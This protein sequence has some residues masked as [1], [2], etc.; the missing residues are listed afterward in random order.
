MSDTHNTILPL[1]NENNNSS[2][3]LISSY[4]QIEPE[5]TLTPNSA[6]FESTN[7]QYHHI[8]MDTRGEQLQ[9]QHPFGLVAIK[10]IPP[11]DDRPLTHNH[12]IFTIDTSY[13]MNETC[14]GIGRLCKLDFIKTSITNTLSLFNS[15]ANKHSISITV[16]LFNDCIQILIDNVVVNNDTIEHAIQLIQTVEAKNGT[17]IEKAM[18]SAKTIIQKHTDKFSTHTITHIFLTDGIPTLGEHS[19]DKL[20]N[21]IPPNINNVFI[22]YGG[23]HDCKLL[24]ELGQEDKCSYHFVDNSKNAGLVLG[25]IVDGILYCAIK[26]ARFVINNGEIY[27]YSTNTWVKELK[28]NSISYETEHLLHIQSQSKNATVTLYG[29]I[30]ESNNIYCAEEE[31]CKVTTNTQ[32]TLTNL[33]PY[34][35]RQ[36]SQELLYKVIQCQLGKHIDNINTLKQQLNQLL[37]TIVTYVQNNDLENDVFLKTLCADVLTTINTIA[38]DNS[39]MYSVSRHTSQGTQRSYSANVRTRTINDNEP[40]QM[41]KLQRHVAG[42]YC[43]FMHDSE[44]TQIFNFDN[45]LEDDDDLENDDDDDEYGKYIGFL[46]TSSPQRIVPVPTLAS[47]SAAQTVQNEG[48]WAPSPYTSQRTVNIMREISKH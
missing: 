42:E 25:E 11:P 6:M 44:Q 31:L 4:I 36:Q 40:I 43:P 34:L 19:P 41:P 5:P 24:L 48:Q 28:I 27:S 23:E 12:F 3:E 22:G 46:A 47:A 9:Q 15:I 8:D 20:K 33:Q 32:Q 26:D 16:Q 30:V 45:D 7:I 21:I 29:S 35:F 2:Q 39:L 13:S 38:M 18:D 10:L 37:E 1:S 17:N 14:N